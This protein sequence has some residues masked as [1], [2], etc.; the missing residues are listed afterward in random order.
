MTFSQRVVSITQDT[1][2]PKIYDNLLNDNFA[3]YRFIGNGKAWTGETLKRPIKYQKN[4]QGSSYSGMDPFSTT[5]VET[6]MTASY[7]VRAYEIPI[8]I[9][10]LERSVNE[11]DAQ[12]LSLV[13]AEIES[14]ANDALDDIGTMFYA[15]GTGNSN[16]DFL[17]LDALDDD[18]TSVVTLANI[19]SSTYT[20]WK[21]TRTSF[22]GVLTLAKLATMNSAI[23]GGSA[24]RQQPTIYVSSET[25]F[26]FYESLLSPTVRANYDINGFPV[27]TRTS[28]GAVASA[29]L[30]GGMGYTSLSHRGIPWVKDEKATVGTVWM[31]NENYLD[32]YG[33]KGAGLKSFTSSSEVIEGVY[34][35]APSKN[36]G[37]QL[38]DFMT[39]T[40]AYGEIAHIHLLGNMTTFQRRRHGRATSVTGV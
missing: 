12:V 39:P 19:S 23:S 7:D 26:D 24:G 14:T 8:V 17:G 15:D 37:L 27:V 3:T 1:I 38:Q 13:K 2:L 22:A 33:L 40:N 31:L 30:K 34:S 21:S 16:K 36:T 11:T 29:E 18:G 25:E 9:P 20:F 6:R 35:D 10:G 4:T 32:W 28:K 5:S